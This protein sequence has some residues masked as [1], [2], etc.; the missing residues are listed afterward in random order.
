MEERTKDM[1]HEN[2]KS[3]GG[4]IENKGHDQ[5]LIV[6]LMSVKCSLGDVFLFHMYLVVAQTKVKF[7]KVLSPIEFIKN[8]IYDR[9]GK[10]VLDGKFVKGTKIRTHAPSAFLLEDHDNRGR[11]VSGTGTNNTRF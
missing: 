7:G 3:G 6:A 9:N 8:A 1:I 2:L 11:I 4:I 10:C 5:E